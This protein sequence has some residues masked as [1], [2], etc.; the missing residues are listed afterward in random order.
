MLGS[1]RSAPV[2]ATRGFG[3]IA[4]HRAGARAEVLRVGLFDQFQDLAEVAVKVD[5]LTER[6]F[7]LVPVRS[8][9][10]VFSTAHPDPRLG[11]LLTDATLAHVIT[12]EN[13]T[14]TPWAGLQFDA[15][16]GFRAVGPPASNASRVVIAGRSGT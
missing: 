9:F 13:S 16:L 6:R 3:L 1:F 11:I 12:Y 4:R 7:K 14:M 2:R 10:S 15:S 5:E 8:W